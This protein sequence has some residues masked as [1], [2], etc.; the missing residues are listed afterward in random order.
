LVVA[1][2]NHFALLCKHQLPRNIS[3]LY[4]ELYW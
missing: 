2:I 1:K 4:Y 3:S